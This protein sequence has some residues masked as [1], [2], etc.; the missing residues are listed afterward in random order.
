I[1]VLGTGVHRELVHNPLIPDELK[2]EF[3]LDDVP[4]VSNDRLLA[5]L[6]NTAATGEQKNE[7]VRINTEARLVALKISFIALSGFA[8][9]ACFPS[10]ALPGAARGRVVPDGE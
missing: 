8:L 4:F 1:S 9:L 7:A 2:A 5:A 10:G 6:A 3:N